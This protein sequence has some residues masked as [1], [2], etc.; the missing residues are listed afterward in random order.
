MPI[1]CSTKIYKV[2]FDDIHNKQR[3]QSTIKVPRDRG[4]SM[5]RV[6][7]Q[8]VKMLEEIKRSML[9][10]NLKKYLMQIQQ[11]VID[12]KMKLLVKINSD[13]EL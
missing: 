7:T 10:V 8:F 9:N 13:F 11:F 2:A 4:P 5:C 6:L 3:I 1:W 12:Y